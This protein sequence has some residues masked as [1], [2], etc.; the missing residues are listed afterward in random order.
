MRLG[1]STLAVST[2]VLAAA[3][4]GSEASGTFSP[5]G[6]P[7]D[8]PVR[9]AAGPS[10]IVDLA[11]TY[12]VE[13]SLEGR[14]VIDFRILVRGP[15]GAPPG[16]YEEEWIAHGTFEGTFAG[17]SVTASLAYTAAVREGGVVDGVLAFGDGLTGELAVDGRFAEGVLRYDGDL[18]R[19]MDE[20]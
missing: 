9:V 18:E 20:G 14:M 13:G 17:D 15:C 16:T 6:P 7:R 1:V 10:C 8:A 12:A 5:A 11:Q 2:F 3:G 19:S 4:P